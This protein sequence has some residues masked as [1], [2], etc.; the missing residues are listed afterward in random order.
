[1]KKTYQEIY[2]NMD[3]SGVLHS[4]EKCCIYGGIVFTNKL[5]Q[6]NFGRKYKSILNKIKCKYCHSDITKCSHICPEIKDTNIKPQHKRWIWNLIKKETCFAVIINNKRVKTAIMNNK[7]SRGRYRDYTQRILI[8]KVIDYLIK[9]KKIDP[10]LP[11]RLT[12]RIDQQATATDTNREFIKDIE[13]ELKVGMV[14]LEYNI[15]HKPI[16]FSDLEIDLKYVL[17]HK[18]ISIQ[19]SDFIAGE[20]RRNIISCTDN[21]ELLKK[22]DYLNVKVFLP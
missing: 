20:T 2:I 10:N 6:E 21:M 17:S 18:H 1:M 12:I 13:K 4:N 14:N 16:L 22:L 9:D 7:D 11:V 15:I 5:E 3:D 19:A 8:K